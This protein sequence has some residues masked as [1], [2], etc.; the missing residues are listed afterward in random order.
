MEQAEYTKGSKITNSKP[1]DKDYLISSRVRTSG[2]LVR[3]N[4]WS[5]M[6][7]EILPLK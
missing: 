3:I 7:V 4:L 5:S 2:C 6:E 1:D